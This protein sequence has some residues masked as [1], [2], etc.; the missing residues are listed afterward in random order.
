MNT[1]WCELGVSAPADK[2]RVS[3]KRR[4]GNLKLGDPVFV[5]HDLRECPLLA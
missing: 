5:T 2:L 4:L 3:W 1:R